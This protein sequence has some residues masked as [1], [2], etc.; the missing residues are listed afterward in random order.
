MDHK[1]DLFSYEIDE[2]RKKYLEML[3]GRLLLVTN[4]DLAS[5]EV[6][7]RYKSLADIVR[8]FRVLK[9]DVEIGPDYH[10]VPRK[11]RAHAMVC[12]FA[13]VLYRLMRMRLQAAN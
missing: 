9:S 13:L 2:A 11:V 6:V 12:F 7:S 4:T 5:S 3:D 10:R 8:G 1:W